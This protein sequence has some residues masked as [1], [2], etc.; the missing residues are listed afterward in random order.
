MMASSPA[1]AAAAAAAAG[2]DDPDDASSSPR[3]EPESEPSGPTHP[4]PA[5]LEAQ[6]WIEA[7]TGK[8]F[9]EKDFRSGLENG[10]LLC[11]LLSA[12]K[13]GLVKKI[14]R[15]PTPI[16]GL[17]NLSVFLRGCEELGLKGSQLFDPGDLQDTSIRANLKDSDCNR[18]LKNVLNTVFW[19]GKAASG[20][21]SYSGPTL[22]LKEF[23]GLLA[24]MRVE[25]EEGGDSSL[26]RSVRDSGYDCWDS[27]RSDSLSPPRHT[28]DNSLDSLDSFGSRSQH[29]PSPDVVNRGNSDGRGSDSEADGR[30]PDVRKDDMLARRTANSD[31]RNSIPFNQFLPNRTNA[32]SYIPTPRRKPH[33]EE[34]EQRSHP[35]ATPEQSKRSG[36]HHKTPKTVTWAPENNEEKLKQEEENMTQ[37]VL[38]QRKLKMLQ[39]AGIKVLPAAVRYNSPPTMEEQ[40]VRSP[41]PNIILRCDNEFLS[42]QKSAWD[43]SSDVEEEAEVRKIPDVHKD[44]LASR[45]AHRS[46]V[47]PRV[48]QFVP[49]PVCSN[50][51]RERWEGIRR[52]SQQTLQEKEISEKEAVPDII[53]RRDNPFLNSSRHE[54]EEDGEEEGEEGQVKATPNKQKD[55]LARRRAQ[56]KPLPHRD[57]PMSFVSAPMSQA[58]VQKWERLKIAEPSEA[59]PVPVCQACLE[60]SYGSPL[61]GSAR[62]GRGHSKVVTFGG[63]T[64]IEQPI[65][66]VTSSEGEE[67]ELLRR[68]LSKATVAMPTI[69]LGSQLSERERSQVDGLNQTSADLPPCTPETPP[70]P[71]ELDAQLAQYERRTEE[72]EEEE[73]EKIPD[74]QKDDMMARRTGVFHKQSS[75]TATYNRFLPLP[76][77]KRCTQGEVTTDAAPRNKRDVQADRSKKLNA[78]VEPLRVPMETPDT[79][80]I[81]ATSHSEREYDDDDNDEYDENEPVPDLEKD[82]MMT[83][84]TGSFQSTARTNQPINKFLPVPGAVKYNVAPVSA[85][86]PLLRT[87]LTERMACESSIVTVA[88]EPQALLSKAPTLPKCA[89]LRRKRQE[90]D[91]KQ[92]GDMTISDTSE[93]LSSSSP[94]PPPSPAAAP[95]RKV[96]AELEK[97]S[98][99]ERVEEKVE[100]RKKDVDKQPRKKPFWLDDDDLP[101]IMSVS[102]SDMLNEEEVGYLPPLSQSRNE[103]MH[104]QYNNFQEDDDHWQS[105]LA[106]WKTRRRSASQE[107]IKKEEERKRMEKRMKE[108]GRDSNKRKS[109]KTYKEIVEEKERREVELCD[110]Y[111]NAATPEEAAMVLQRYALRFTI[112]DATLDSLKL[113]RSTANTKQDP[114]QVD[115]EHKTTSPVNETSER[116]HKPEPPVIKD[117]RHTEPEEME[118]LVTAQQE[119]SVSVSCSSPTAGSPR[120]P[121]SNSE[122]VPP[123]SL[124][125]KEPQPKPTE[126]QTTQQKQPIT[127]DAKPQ[128]KHTPPQISL[129]QPHTTKPGHTLPSP[130]SVSPRPVP[131]LAAKPY[132]QPRSTQSGHKPVKMDGLVRVNGEAMEDLSVSSP[133]ASARHSPPEVKDIP[134]EQTEKDVPSKLTQKDVPSEQTQKDVP[135]KLTQKD[136]PSEQ[137][138]KDVPSKLTQKDVP[139]KQTENDVPSEQAMTNQETVEQTPPPQTERSTSSLGSA[140]SSLIGGRNCTITTT[141]VTELTHVEPHHPDIQSNGQVNGTSEFPGSPVEEAQPATSPNSMQE[142]SPTVS[143]GLEESSVTI[144]TPMLNLAKRVNHW[145]W[146][147]NEERKRLESWQ[148]EQERLLQEQYQREQE[149]LKKEWEKAQLEVQEE[150]RKHNEEERKIL[151]ETVTPLNPAGLLNQTG[152]TPSAPENNKTEGGSVPL[153]Q[154]GQRREGNE[155]QHATKLHF[156]QDTASDGEPLKKQEVWKTASLDRNPGLNQPH[157]VKRS[158]SH[159]AVIN[160]QQPSPSSPQPPSPSRCVSGKR[161]CSGCSQQLGKGAAMII[162]TLGLFFHMQCFKCGVCD[163]QLGD[164]TVGTDVRIRNGL[165]SC[166]E[167]Y[168]A[169]RGRGQP[170]TL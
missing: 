4:E 48:H 29:S 95:A 100:E 97:Q 27:E 54:E 109:I 154:N 76:S 28:R 152:M 112:S 57:G 8:S 87:K 16:A 113:P 51:D 55:D 5:C 99:E 130:P 20:C 103:R 39:K 79:T 41:S 9:G 65:D 10:I 146:D 151:E 160:K 43:S 115:K 107:L 83:R 17:D 67:T 161:L 90:E 168:I 170:T 123:R 135:S 133:P 132:C 136:V 162:D 131:L 38:E 12:I 110:A 134:S 58:D 92:E 18:K 69:G 35:Q 49:S 157:I 163:G 117:Q 34:G 45:R 11:E 19:L 68:L 98:V 78:R 104:E 50:K 84:R 70:T 102:M 25:T 3:D 6:K 150:E 81:R 159:D 61:S 166:H 1:A 91:G 74:V 114:T 31:S 71:A 137:T 15:L 156:F 47:A 124:E 14:N 64:E 40:E 122:N 106:R 140:I 101:P 120:S 59:S 143:E 158:E 139:S 63:V 2:R 164:A 147:P 42:S 121:V 66:T 46:P 155:D 111:R 89:G 72:D 141:I 56:S 142:Y 62:A 125:L 24:Q 128:T 73:E 33:T 30:R 44:D 127:G 129:V 86:K 148:Q 37:D 82:D 116:L 165:L 85:M 105:D 22:N 13:P 75:A 60:K 96:E 77:T 167:C 7:V 26:K 126:S 32:S 108:E 52:A 53:T 21:A 94:T 36:L 149:K 118:T 23:E 153:Q 138:Q 88:A 80:V 119:T 144:E 145:V 93:P 169:S